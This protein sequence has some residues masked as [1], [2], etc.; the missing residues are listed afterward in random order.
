VVAGIRKILPRA[1]LTLPPQLKV[2]PIADQYLFVRG[3][4]SGVIR[5]AVML[6]LRPV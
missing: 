1:A 6:Q 3:A 5:E 4:I 2:T